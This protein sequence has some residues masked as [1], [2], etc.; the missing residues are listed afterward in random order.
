MHDVLVIGGGPAGLS[1]A[2]VLGRCR[3]SVLV[4]DEGRPRNRFSRQVRGFLTRDGT[5]PL[6]LLSI[7]LDQLSAYPNVRFRSGKIFRVSPGNDFFEAKL[8]NGATLRART[9]LLATGI[10]DELP[11]IPDIGKFYG[12]SV[13]HC[14]YCD[15]WE[16][17]DESIAVHGAGRDG[18]DFVQEMLGWSRN[19]TFCT[20]GLPLTPA[21]LGLLGKMK[22]AVADAPISGLDGR[23]GLL[24]AISF[25]DGS[26]LACRALF[27]AGRQRQN[28]NL[29]RELGCRFAADHYIDCTD[30]IRT[31]IPGVFAAGNTSG[32]LQLDIVAAAEGARAAWAINQDLLAREGPAF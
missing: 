32:G 13:H 14:P 25:A 12:T 22:I 18:I 1:A 16:H 11:D 15:G 31:S 24:E 2:L 3:R 8:E 19:L 20:H 23:S 29:A 28:S 26:R 4:C 9:I 10:V 7:A 17:R 27:F 21:D 30:N 6:E 5:P